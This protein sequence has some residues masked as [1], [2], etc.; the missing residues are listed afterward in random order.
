MCCSLHLLQCFCII[1]ITSSSIMPGRRYIWR[2]AMSEFS[3]C[4]FL[5]FLCLARNSPVPAAG[6]TSLPHIWYCGMLVL[7]PS[8]FWETLEKRV[9]WRS[10]KVLVLT[11]PWIIRPTV[12]VKTLIGHYVR[13]HGF[14]MN[15]LWVRCLMLRRLVCLR[16]V[17][18][19]LMASP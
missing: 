7:L 1:L 9:L 16:P 11:W 3:V 4:T 5:A 14:P 19:M 15:L 2:I 12:V 18:I 8:G 6:G 13:Q 17:A 10:Y